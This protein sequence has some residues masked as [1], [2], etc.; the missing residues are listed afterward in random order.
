MA[1]MGRSA[2]TMMS[3]G[4][5]L[6]KARQAKHEAGQGF[7]VHFAKKDGSPQKEPSGHHDTLEKAQ[8]QAAYLAKL[9]PKTSA[10]VVEKATGNVAHTAHGNESPHATKPEEG[11]KSPAQRYAAAMRAGDSE[12]AAKAATG[13]GKVRE[14]KVQEASELPG[15]P[16]HPNKRQAGQTGDSKRAIDVGS[17]A[18]QD[19]TLDL[20]RAAAKAHGD[21]LEEAQRQNRQAAADYHAHEAHHHATSADIIE[22]DFEG[23]PPPKELTRA[24]HLAEHAE[25]ATKNAS[26]MARKGEGTGAAEHVA[27]ADAHRKAAA[28]FHAAGES[29]AAQEHEQKAA[30]HTRAAGPDGEKASKLAAFRDKDKKPEHSLE[31]GA[32]GG[33]YYL[34]KTGQKVYV[35]KK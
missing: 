28:A 14:V 26:Y 10:H 2:K 24:S 9:N 27:A 19:N 18:D 33:Q 15:R 23:Q 20:H 21:A 29:R 16:E 4:R 25:A 3:A 11:A 31:T 13:A 7:A 34:S 5:T 12:G 17:R 1:M 32:K 6:E 30:Q 22:R 8:A 35:G